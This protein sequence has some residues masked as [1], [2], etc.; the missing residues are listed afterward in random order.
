MYEK[1]QNQFSMM[2]YPGEWFQ[3]IDNCRLNFNNNEQMLFP[4]RYGEHFFDRRTKI[5]TLISKFEVR[6]N[7][8]TKKNHPITIS[9]RIS[10]VLEVIFTSR[11]NFVQVNCMSS[12]N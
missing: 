6:E 9:S 7:S 12:M 11:K 5:N 4:D 8:Q 1:Y 10:M 3:L 2:I